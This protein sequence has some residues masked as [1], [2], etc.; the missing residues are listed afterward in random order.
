VS[1]ADVARRR[2]AATGLARPAEAS[3]HLLYA[4]IVA[5]IAGA[6]LAIEIMAPEGWQPDMIWLLLAPAA[7]LVVAGIPALI[8]S[9][10]SQR[11]ERQ[12]Q[13]KDDLIGLLLKDYAAERGDWV[14][15]CDIDG[16]LRGVSQK[17]ALHAGR[18]SGALE[19]LP[20]ADLLGETH[21]SK[22]GDA[23]H[24]TVSMRQR[25]AFYNLEARINAGGAECTW[26]MAGKP[27]FRDGR[28]AGY[29]GT[30]ANITSEF[31]AKETM[32]Y[33]A[34][35]DGLTGLS[36]RTHFQKR[37]AECAARLDRYGTAFT[38]LY[39]DL[40]RFKAVNDRLGHQ[41]GDQLLI[42]VGKRLGA[43]V[44]RA[45]LVARLGGDEFALLLP[46]ESDPN[47]V[48]NLTTRLIEQICQPFTIGG[49]A[50]S[51][52]VSIG[53]AIAPANG[54]Q[55]EQIVRNADLALYR[56][57]AD[58]GSNYC[59]FEARMD[60][61]VHDRHELE[62]ELNEALERNE[63]VFHYQPMMAAGDSTMSGVEALIRWNHPT[64]GLVPPVEFIPLAERSGL[65]GRIGEW[66]IFEACRALAQLPEHLTLAVNVSARH[67]RSANIA[68]VVEQA[69]KA[70]NVAPHRLELEI[71]E[72]LLIEHLG[73][74]I[75]TLA[76]LKKLGTTISLDHFGTGYSS[77]SCLRKFAFD[78]I[79]IDD[80][81]VGAQGEQAGSRETVRAIMAL[82]RTL[83]IAVAAEGVETIDQAEFLR[84][85]GLSQLQG[86]LFGKPM[87]LADVLGTDNDGA[88]AGMPAEPDKARAEAVE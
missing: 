32:T 74:A 15:S 13:E 29:V 4:A 25:K 50:L 60:E 78:K 9:R 68:V 64:R 51:I 39:L 8:V 41:A 19:G 85:T 37:L 69:L 46:D 1:P 16:K 66:K 36:N 27:L 81:L 76:E 77:L 61:E 5:L 38:L 65:I 14:W 11:I 67:F 72:N 7:G 88:P 83:E 42:E 18:P 44:R 52:G 49:E 54:E 55:A 82:A 12:A 62:L 79:K 70:A 28:F 56:A 20:L 2:V 47:N 73:E 34:Y 33:L 23:D 63:L 10:R 53:I 17:F 3:N 71:T 26:R 24:V 59:F 35:N 57:K 86:P 45:D 40:D 43:Q 22:D 58:G 80:S 21:A 30:A 84:E 75:D 48:A 87:P 6:C 31:R